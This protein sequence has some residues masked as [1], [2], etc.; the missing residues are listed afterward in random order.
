MCVIIRMVIKLKKN[1]VLYIL[2]SLL[3]FLFLS[4]VP[5]VKILLEVKKIESLLLSSLTIFYI[6]LFV[7]IIIVAVIEIIYFIKYI[8]L[9]KEFSIIK[10]LIW[11]LLLVVLNVIIL[12]YFI[13]KYVDKEERILFNY[14]LYLVPILFFIIIFIFGSSCYM[15]SINEI[16]LKEKMIEEER[17]EYKTK[18]EKASFTF[19]H[20]YIKDDI[21]EYDLYVINK[22]NN[23]IFTAFT[24]DTEKYEQKTS[25]DYIKKGI[26]D[27]EEG[28]EKFELLNKQKVVEKDDKTI[29]TV[30]YAGKT[31]DSSLCVYRISTI[32]FKSNPNYLI[33]TVE[34]I[35]KNTYENNLDILN[36]ILES[37]KLY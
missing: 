7:L 30:E 16:R 33:Y 8:I 22:S 25:E 11:V 32:V 13:I 23:I 9:N 29:T 24:Y 37:A 15:K 28:K 21:G 4:I 35:T 18:D 34:V 19:R 17:N 14:S 1:K 27:I 36:E 2:P 20:G 31:K 3:I 12:P 5:I 6:L 26:S 10:K